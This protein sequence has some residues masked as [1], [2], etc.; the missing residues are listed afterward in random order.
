MKYLDAC[1]KRTMISVPLYRGLI[2]S[3]YFR[4]RDERNAIQSGVCLVHAHTCGCCLD[5]P[6]GMQTLI[7]QSHAHITNFYC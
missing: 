6:D 4:F 7:I 1:F 2:K 5:A 3:R